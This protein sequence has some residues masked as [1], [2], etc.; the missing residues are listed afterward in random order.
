M[1]IEEKEC[2]MRNFRK[3]WII[4]CSASVGAKKMERSTGCSRTVGA[5]AGEKMGD[6]GKK[7]IRIYIFQ[8]EK[9]Y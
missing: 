4:Q 6:L 7:A 9:R 2:D 8:N 3:K 5:K 1:G